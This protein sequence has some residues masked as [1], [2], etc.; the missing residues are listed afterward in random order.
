MGS[1]S[2]DFSGAINSDMDY[3]IS[4]G[5]GSIEIQI[6]KGINAIIATDQSILASLDFEDMVLI[7]EMMILIKGNQL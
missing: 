5:M 1:I 6:P 3:D 2:F 4:V 7:I